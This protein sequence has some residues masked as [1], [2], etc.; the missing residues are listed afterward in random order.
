MCFVSLIKF[1]LRLLHSITGFILK[2]HLQQS[3]NT[4]VSM[5]HDHI[6]LLY[7]LLPLTDLGWLLQFSPVICVSWCLL[8]AHGS[9]W[10]ANLQHNNI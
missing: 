10:L 3:S 7:V 4:Y 1:L 8:M 9:L 2:G 5:M 6:S